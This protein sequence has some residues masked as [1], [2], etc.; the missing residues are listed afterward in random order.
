[1][2][3]H[4]AEQPQHASPDNQ[5]HTPGHTLLKLLRLQMQCVENSSIE[6][7]FVK[8]HNAYKQIER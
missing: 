3:V 4:Q 2:H 7:D 1:M 8:P 6:V 5:F